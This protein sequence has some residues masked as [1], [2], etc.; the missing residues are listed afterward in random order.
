M[1]QR[2]TYLEGQ[3]ME[4]GAMTNG[5]DVPRRFDGKDTG[6]TRYW[7]S[8]DLGLMGDYSN[9]YEWLDSQNAEECGSSMASL[10]SIKTRDQII[11][12]IQNIFK[13]TPRARAYIISILPDG[14][15]GGKFIAGGRKAAPWAGFAVH[16][17]SALDEAYG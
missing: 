2:Y 11:A 12:E 7:I 16:A 17:S 4:T 1:N 14:R 3:S 5:E 10:V 9:F 8:Y 6:K 15:F 13:G